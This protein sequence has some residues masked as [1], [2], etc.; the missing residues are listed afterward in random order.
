MN[1]QQIKSAIKRMGLT[2]A[3]L[4]NELNVSQQMIYLI[5]NGQ[6]KSYRIQK[7]ISE[8]IGQPIGRIW[9]VYERI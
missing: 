8:L 7:F 6:T 2:Q 4:A 1:P 9:P 3:D 5:I